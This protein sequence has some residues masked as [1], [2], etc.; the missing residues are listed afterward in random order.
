MQS[1][2]IQTWSSEAAQLSLTPER[3]MLQVWNKKDMMMSQLSWEKPP[4]RA[5]QR[6]ALTARKQKKTNN[7]IEKLLKRLIKTYKSILIAV[8]STT[9]QWDKDTRNNTET[10]FN[11]KTSMFKTVL[12]NKKLSMMM[13]FSHQSLNQW[14]LK[15][16]P[17][18]LTFQTSPRILPAWAKSRSNNHQRAKLNKLN[19]IKRKDLL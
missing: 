12:S 2:K 19:W 14:S 6:V 8:N 15:N 5:H 4:W 17:K 7:I 10:T 16:Q 3:E 18:T 11:L 9:D 13:N 1:I